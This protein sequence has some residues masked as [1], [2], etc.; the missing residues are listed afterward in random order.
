MTFESRTLDVP[1]GDHFY[2]KENIYILAPSEN[3]VKVIMRSENCCMFVKNTMFKNKILSRSVDDIKAYFNHWLQ[4]IKESGFLDP[5]L[6][7]EQRQKRIEEELRSVRETGVAVQRRVPAMPVVEEVQEVKKLEEVKGEE[8]G[9]EKSE[10][11][12][13]NKITEK[14]NIAPEKMSK[15]AIE[16]IEMIEAAQRAVL[17]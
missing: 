16:N 14:N 8:N 9:P 12:E 5:E 1:F 13:E 2:M 7:A 10:V 15:K 4:S 11:K 6:H 3:S 17:N